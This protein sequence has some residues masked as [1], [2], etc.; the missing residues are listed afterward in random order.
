[1]YI[2]VL[3]GGTATGLAPQG[4]NTTTGAGDSAGFMGSIQG[5]PAVAY[6]LQLGNLQS[7]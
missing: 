2:E 7:S 6:K 4:S 1:M 5:R 3:A